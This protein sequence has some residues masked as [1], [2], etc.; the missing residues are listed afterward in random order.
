M[1]PTTTRSEAE[2]RKDLEALVLELL[3]RARSRRAP[4]Y[5]HPLMDVGFD[6][7]EILE[8]ID[9][10]LA[11]QITMGA[12]VRAFEAA[13]AEWLGVGHAIMANSGSS[14]NL[15]AVA[16]LRERAGRGGSVL[17]PAVTWATSVFPLTQ[18]GYRVHFTDVEL[19]T[20]RMDMTGV[21]DDLPDDFAGV[22]AVHLLGSPSRVDR[23]ADAASARG[24][25]LVE[26][27][28]EAMG[29]TLQ[30]RKLGTHGDAG[31]FSFFFSHHITTGEG[32]M[33]VTNDD[34]L[35]DTMR[36]KRAHGW[37]RER[38][39]R[40]Q[41]EGAHPDI[42]PRYLFVTDGYNLRP[43][44]IS[45]AFGLHQ[46]PRIAGF[47]QE[48]Q[49]TARRWV[50]IV[51]REARLFEPLRD[52]APGEHGWFAL[53]L[54][55]RQD[56]PVSRRDLVARLEKAGIETRPIMAGDITQQPALVQIRTT[57]MSPLVNAQAI[58]E[59]GIMIGNY[60]G[61][62]ESHLRRLEEVLAGIA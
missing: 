57:R 1:T 53:P 40:A 26:D 50:D 47:L 33:V 32:G 2:L 10:L 43:T 15:L 11:S 22:L 58:H 14:A 17:T 56:A 9:S 52:P 27:C 44:E 42:D 3:R 24:A 34:A 62:D 59:R 25:W 37:T 4:T 7:A 60:P 54:V 49:G 41:I 35:A 36:S 12:K 19:D 29:A 6:G 55:L 21:P 18:H 39:D 51:R 16:A 38:R 20:F 23:L 5:A 46:L 45:G 28:C 31:T 13:F 30:G 61:L 48:R 8:A